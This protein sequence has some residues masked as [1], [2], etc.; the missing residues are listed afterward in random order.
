MFGFGGLY[1]LF[2]IVMMSDARAKHLIRSFSERLGGWT[3]VC[4]FPGHADRAVYRS[5]LGHLHHGRY[6]SAVFIWVNIA[7]PTHT[8]S[9]DHDVIIKRRDPG[10]IWAALCTGEC[11]SVCSHHAP[12]TSSSHGP[13]IKEDCLRRQSENRMNTNMRPCS[14]LDDETLWLT[15]L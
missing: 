2:Y 14:V 1:E 6:S 10:D 11:D 13:G 7:F 12:C 5:D 15:G 8:K 3:Q 4:L 9:H